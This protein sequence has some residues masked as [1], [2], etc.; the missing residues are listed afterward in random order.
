MEYQNIQHA[1]W[2][3]ACPSRGAS[4]AIQVDN[5]YRERIKHTVITMV[6]VVICMNDAITEVEVI[7]YQLEVTGQCLKLT[8]SDGETE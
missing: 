3:Y 5:E 7:G 6:V 8:A 1:G 4:V 2:I